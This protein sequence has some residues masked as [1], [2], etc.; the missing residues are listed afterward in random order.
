MMKTRPLFGFESLTLQA[1]P[2]QHL[3]RDT[4][5]SPRGQPGTGKKDNN[6]PPI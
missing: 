4:T 1:C 5:S 6:Q 2:I 3:D